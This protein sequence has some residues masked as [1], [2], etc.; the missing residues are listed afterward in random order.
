[1]I[2]TRHKSVPD[3][4]FGIGLLLFALLHLRGITYPPNG[5]HQWRESDTAAIILNYYQEDWS[6]LEPRINQRGDGSGI[7]GM[8]FPVYQ[9]LSALGYEV[10]GPYHAVPR[11]LTLLG[12]L[13]GALFFYLTIRS[14]FDRFTAIGA[15]LGLLFSPLYLFYSSKIMPDIWMLAFLAAAVWMFFRFLATGSI[16]AMIGFPLL[17]TLS[18]C[19]KPLGLCVFLP[20]LLTAPKHSR[21]R[22]AVVWLGLCA[23]VAIGL[24]W[25][26]FTYARTVSAANGGGGFFLGDYIPEF[27][28]TI[29][30]VSFFKHIFIQW[31]WELW[32]GYA[33]VPIFCFGLYSAFRNRQGNFYL[34]WIVACL[35]VFVPAGAHTSSHDY[36]SLPIVLPMALLTGLGFGALYQ[37]REWVRGVAIAL[38]LVAPA[39]ATARIAHRTATT[40]EFEPLRAVADTYI[41][42][43]SLVAVEEHT[44]AIKLY[45][46]NRHGW[47][48]RG[49]MTYDKL[50]API[51]R[52][53]EFVILEQPLRCYDTAIA[54]LLDTSPVSTNPMFVYHVRK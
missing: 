10:I 26:W 11:L 24:T 14:Q 6:F 30:V 44:S 45:Q 40:P 15:G 46:L 32:L 36:Y 35:I 29:P 37:K 23:L 52:G 48:I 38:M 2:N 28:K 8:E 21:R 1:M 51:D 54:R 9:Y 18:A 33:V 5:Y 4:V 22:M 19:I 20:A 42:R 12:G 34:W 16:V 43:T 31:P 41:P 47:P 50:R 49:D 39:A 53:A 3:I 25:L 27:W 7:T 13:V 17:L